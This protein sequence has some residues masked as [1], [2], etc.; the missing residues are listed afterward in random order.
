MVE[1]FFYQESYDPIRIENEVCSL[2]VLISNH[3]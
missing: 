3:G 1:S 2:G